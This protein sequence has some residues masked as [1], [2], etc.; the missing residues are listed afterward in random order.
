MSKQYHWNELCFSKSGCSGRRVAP[1]INNHH[2]YMAVGSMEDRMAERC[3]EQ[4]LQALE[5][6]K[7]RKKGVIRISYNFVCLHLKSDIWL[8]IINVSFKAEVE[9]HFQIM[10]SSGFCKTQTQAKILFLNVFH[11]IPVSVVLRLLYVWKSKFRGL[12]NPH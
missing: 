7:E 11:F 9:S 6:Y 12:E 10:N 1:H 4:W 3:R 2:L 8:R 5:K